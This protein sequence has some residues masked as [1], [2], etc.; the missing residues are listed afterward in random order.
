MSETTV[1][2]PAAVI[3]PQGTAAVVYRLQMSVGGGGKAK[4]EVRH[5]AGGTSIGAAEAS[6]AMGCANTSQVIADLNGGRCT[7]VVTFTSSPTG[8]SWDISVV[9]FL[10]AT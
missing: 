5:R 10:R 1:A 9:G 6:N 8:V 2:L 4:L 3:A 7:Y